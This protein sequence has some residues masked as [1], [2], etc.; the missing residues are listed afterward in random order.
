MEA[1][2]LEVDK[3]ELLRLLFYAFS[4]AAF[5]EFI[6][7]LLVYRR[8]D[9]EKLSAAFDRASKRLEKKKEEPALPQKDDGKKGKDGKKNKEDKKLVMLERD[10]DIA[11]RD[12]MII[13]TRSNM[14]TAIFHLFMFF[15]LKASYEGLIIARLPFVPLSFVSSVSHRSLPG[16]DM[17]DCGMIFVYM[18]CSMS[19]KPN[20]QKFLGH[21]PPKTALPLHAQKL[22]EKW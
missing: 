14:I 19:I 21:T 2:A 15:S 4:S 3:S 5:C 12:L 16:T 18:L 8:A 7:W 13:K 10:Y 1:T 17:Q 20:L 6:S 22:A 11:N 9:Y